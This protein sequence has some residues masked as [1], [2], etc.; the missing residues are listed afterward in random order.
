MGRA[1]KRK[2]AILAPETSPSPA[3]LAVMNVTTPESSAAGLS[4]TQGADGSSY[5]ACQS[6]TVR[7]SASVLLGSKSTAH[8]R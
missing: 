8:A 1:N 3:Q 4:Q 7:C 5:T 2:N 6:T